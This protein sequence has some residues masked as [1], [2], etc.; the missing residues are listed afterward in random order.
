MTALSS[1]RR[2]HL[3]CSYPKSGR[4]WLRMILA[5]YFCEI[6]AYPQCDDFAA[7]FALL[8]NNDRDPQRGLPAFAYADDLRMPLLWFDHATSGR[9]PLQVPILLILRGALDTVVSN[10]FQERFRLRRYDGSADDF[11]LSHPAGL[12]G[13]V[14][15]VNDWAQDMPQRSQCR[16]ITYEQ[17]HVQTR[18]VCIDVLRL[19]SV[20]PD[21]AALDRA[22][23]RSQ[24]LNM[25]AMER[26]SGF[27][28]LGRPDAEGPA[29]LR[30]REGRVG[31]YERHLSSAVVD[32][33]RLYAQRRL[34]AAAKALL[35][36]QRLGEDLGI[37]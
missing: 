37:G 6:N 13:W 1:Q 18:P 36:A 30:A 23:D 34:N 9:V 31:G 33:L 27:P 35:T 28:G 32:Q 8:P 12:R 10:Y 19:L 7:M 20:Q 3:C 22:I 25:Q 21:P 14:G 29:A 4:T 26:R 2:V 16:I 15:Y 5:N 17:L 11:A 24:L